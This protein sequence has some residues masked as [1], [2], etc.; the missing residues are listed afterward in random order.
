VASRVDGKAD[1]N[2]VAGSFAIGG[3]LSVSGIG[4]E[5]RTWKTALTGRTSGTRSNDPD[6]A[7]ASGLAASS[8]YELTMFL[9]Y[10]SSVGG[11]GLFMG[12][13]VPSG[14]TGRWG[15]TFNKSGVGV[16]NWDFDFTQTVVLGTPAGQNNGVVLKGTLF[17]TN[18][19]G[20]NLAWASG[21][22]GVNVNLND[23]S[24]LIMRRIG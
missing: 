6:L 20:F 14:A 18:S 23:G 2:G 22:A 5:I 12:F 1:G 9:S 11:N 21:G 15:G 10:W 13:G 3:D 7:I 19:G 8:V 16:N 4:Q 17:T 24:H